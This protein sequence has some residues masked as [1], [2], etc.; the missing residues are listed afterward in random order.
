MRKPARLV[1]VDTAS[2]Q[3]ADVAC[4]GETDDLFFDAARGRVY[5]IGGEGF[6]DVFDARA[7]GPYDRLARIPTAAGARTGLWVPE[8]SR[9]YVASPNRD[10]HE[11]AIHV[12]EAP[13]PPTK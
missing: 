12:L 9:L 1:V 4:V 2:H 10:G 3:V 5:V 7:K 11:A 8:M 6:V 13:L